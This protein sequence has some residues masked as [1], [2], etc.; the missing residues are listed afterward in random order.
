LEEPVTAELS[1]PQRAA[2]ALIA[3]IPAAQAKS[4]RFFNGEM[5]RFF[6]SDEAAEP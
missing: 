5:Q 1:A 2:D 4:S 6:S 3:H